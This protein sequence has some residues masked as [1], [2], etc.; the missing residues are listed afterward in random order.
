MNDR[1]VLEIN[2]ANKEYLSQT[3]DSV[4]ALANVSLAVKAG[5]FVSIVGPSGCGKTTLLEA[6]AGLKPL[7]SGSVFVKG[8]EINST[9][10][11]RRVGIVFQEDTVFPWRT[12][13]RN[14]EFGLEMRGVASEVRRRQAASMIELVGL[15]GFQDAYPAEL[16]G[17]MRQ[18]VAVARTLV[19]EP[20]L[21]LLD[22]PFGALD[23]QTR[24]ILADELLGMVDNLGTSVVLVTHSI[25]EAAFV[26]DRIMVLSARPGSV[27]SMIDGVSRPR[28]LAALGSDRLGRVETDIWNS[29]R[30]EILDQKR[31]E[32]LG[33]GA[34]A[35]DGSADV[36]EGGTGVTDR[37]PAEGT[38]EDRG[39]HG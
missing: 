33:P 15:S 37:G 13:L 5:E 31:Q 39:L 21:L 12:V 7:T 34:G 32:A 4:R 11:R 25:E 36:A 10:A 6:A 3:G 17:G 23:A 22:E 30:D 1:P 2:S 26:S 16:S 19:M 28:G 18:R 35:G 14:V 27:K 38:M 24:L 29:L 20:E 8:D 9:K